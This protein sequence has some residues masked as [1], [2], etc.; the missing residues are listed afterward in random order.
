VF[1]SVEMLLFLNLISFLLKVWNFFGREV[2]FE[3]VDGSK[4]SARLT[5]KIVL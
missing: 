3:R 5:G 2:W 4:P 1:A